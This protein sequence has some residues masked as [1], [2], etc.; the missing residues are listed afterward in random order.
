[1]KK[2]PSPLKFQ[3]LL[4]H[5]QSLFS[6]AIQ[7]SFA[8]EEKA[9]ISKSAKDRPSH[10]QCNSAMKLAK[11]FDKKP[12]DVARLLLDNLQD[13]GLIESTEIAGPGFINITI[14]KEVLAND[15]NHILFDPRLGV[16]E[17]EKKERII[18]EFSS[19]NIAKAMH[20]GHLRSTIIGDSIARLLEFLGHDVIRLN[21][22]GDWGTQF[23]MLIAYLKIHQRE[24]LEGGKP[25]DIE[26][27]MQWY[28]D[29]KVAFDNDPS[30]KTTA[31]EEVVKLQ[32]GD[33]NSIKAWKLICSL[34]RASFADVYDTLGVHIEERGESFYNPYLAKVVEDFK[35]KGLSKIDG[36]ATCVFLDGFKNKDDTPLPLIIQKKDGGYN[37]ATTDLAGF[38]YRITEDKA[39]RI[40]IVTDVGQAMHFK[41]VVAAAEKVGYLNNKVRFDH[42]TFGLV[43]APDGKKF[44]T[45]SGETER[46]TD[47]LDEA[48]LQAKALLKDRDVE[49]M[50]EAAKVL[51]IGSVK[52]ADLSCN[53]I[54]DYTFSYERMLRFEGN[55]AAFILYAYVRIQSIKRKI[56]ID[57]EEIAKID[58]IALS[59]PAEVALGL[60]LRQFGETLKS[61]DEELLPNR[62]TDYLFHLAELFHSFFR[63]CHVAGAQE[64][65]S[66]LLLAELTGRIL[67][68]GL[69]ILGIG[70]LAKM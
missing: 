45:R 68:K 57:I 62:L 28:K 8:I 43:L 30:F 40:I 7:K 67:A 50:E 9:E 23:G 29:S 38:L 6:E 4:T 18:C 24:F 33:S 54:K 60:A 13:D 52:Y 34:S 20:V 16:P 27:L 48:V 66:R 69:S 44:K 19:P 32:S 64:Q 59:H 51:G 65:N 5:L 36:D 17:L 35:N 25:V 2:S 58:R 47:L 22:V 14:S 56:G 53:R 10:Y 46:L 70:I 11:T 15:L 49:N 31:Q 42:V 39:E 26:D 41:M 61:M 12:Q 55:T 63:D 21:H 3:N 1:M 37:Y